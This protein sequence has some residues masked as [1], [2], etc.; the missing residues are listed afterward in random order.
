MGTRRPTT[1][2]AALAFKIMTDPFRRLYLSLTFTQ[3]YSGKLRAADYV[4]NSISGN[5][6]ASGACF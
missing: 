4:L 3:I 6:S 1:N 2:P 5:R